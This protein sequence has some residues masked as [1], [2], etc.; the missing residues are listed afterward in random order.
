VPLFELKGEIIMIIAVPT[1]TSGEKS[2]ISENFGRCNFFYIYDTDTEIGKVYTNI[3]KDGQHGVGLRAAEFVLNQK[4]DILITPRVGEKSLEMFKL[5]QI[6][7]YECQN[8]TV[9]DNITKFLNNE[10]KELH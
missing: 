6:K 9:K 8:E 2:F 5:S 4:A 1:S 7:I 10:L 3:Y